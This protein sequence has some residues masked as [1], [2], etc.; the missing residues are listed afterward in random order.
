MVVEKVFFDTDDE[1]ELF[2]LLH[3]PSE[4][5]NKCVIAV[6]GL[7][8]NC[9]KKRDDSLAKI[10]CQNNISYFCFN[11]RGHDVVSNI[12]KQGKKKLSG[13]A[14][15]D[16]LDSYYDIKAAV[17]EINKNGYNEIYIQ[18]HSLGCVKTIYTYNKLLENKEENILNLIKGIML[19]SFVEVQDIENDKQKVN[20]LIQYAIEKEKIGLEDKLIEGI[21]IINIISV[22]TFLRYFKYNEEILYPRYSDDKYDFQ[23]VNNIKCPIFMRWGNVNEIIR[24]DA[25]KLV[26][27]VNSKI[28][29]DKKDINLIDGA[30]H[31]YHEKYEQLANEEVNFINNI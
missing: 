18:A 30:G 25:S 14:Y 19:L 23:E 28:I 22:K 3:S 26:E 20:E 11:N 15:E 16:V 1:V 2:G 12:T 9:L 17:N 13:A 21:P 4:K 10:M 5:T 6:H 8:S 24:Q 29:N 27:L 7:A 31:N